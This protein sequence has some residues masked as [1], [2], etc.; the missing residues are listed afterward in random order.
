VGIWFL[1]S[2]F[3]NYF[4]GFLGTLWERMPHNAFF[5]ILMLL[6]ISGGAAIWLLG[7]PLDRVV[8][9]DDREVHHERN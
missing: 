4:S 8:A 9:E 2:F 1:S 3:G 7:R 5:L 6:G